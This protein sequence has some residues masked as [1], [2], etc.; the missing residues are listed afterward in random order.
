MEVLS[1]DA[2]ITLGVLGGM[3]I[4]LVLE[5]WA[6][7]LIFFCALGLLL[8]TGVLTPEEA[9]V[10][11]SNKG[12]LTVGLLFVVAS[13]AQSSGA[14]N[15]VANRLLG[16]GK[17]LSRALARLM[18]GVFGLSAF[19]NNTPIVAMF[20]PTLREWAQRSGHQPSKVLMPLSYAAIF[21]GV[22]TLI[23]TSTNLVV[24]GLL[25][26]ELDRSLAMFDFAWIGLPCAL[27]GGAYML[28]I[29]ERLLP[30]RGDGLQELAA[31][32]REYLVE[33]R[34]EPQS[35]LDGRTVE[36]AGLR[37]LQGLFLAEVIRNGSSLVPVRRTDRLAAGDRLVFTGD[38]SAIIELQKKP[39]LRPEQDADLYR[40][41]CRGGRGRL[42]EAV[43]SRSSPMLGKTIKAGGF[44]GRYDA[45]ILAVHRNGERIQ[46]KI[47]EIE[48]RPGDTLL[49]MCGDDF[50]QRWAGSRE[51]YMVSQL[52]DAPPLNRPKFLLI[53]GAVAAMVLMA[54]LGMLDIFHGA[55]LATMVLL[56]GGCISVVEA[57]RSIELNVLLVIAC[58]LGI[59]KAMAKTGLADWLA[60]A[61]LDPVSAWG[62]VAL[63]AAVCLITSVL[64]EVITNNAAAALMFPVAVAAAQQQGVDPLPFAVGIAVCASA[65][66][67]TPIGYQ[68]NLMVYG[69]GGYRFQDFM[70]VGIPLNLLF[71]VTCAVVIPW[72]WSF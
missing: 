52:T 22:C 17:S 41:L 27:V 63:L 33:M 70:R 34:V 66:F 14:L 72:V 19:L 7:D 30:E 11:F 53:M 47:G 1:V 21:G 9:L 37:N 49:L 69:P 35:P 45:A 26:Q 16:R 3:L 18:G 71:V 20:V 42:V 68:T 12:M 2:Y 32:G 13:A 24:N 40:H 67:A 38:V 46:G 59:S 6:P 15:Y 55:V 58:A 57:R 44:R 31:A 23:G 64:T 60:Q 48:L 62:P 36:E 65:S 61:L 5:L 54:A 29:G 4:A 10:G 51:F 43:V 39:G 56:L 8:L 25:Q 50:T 28:F